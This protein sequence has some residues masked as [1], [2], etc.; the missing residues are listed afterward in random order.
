MLGNGLV[1]NFWL[2]SSSTRRQIDL[3]SEAEAGMGVGISSA[4][5]GRCH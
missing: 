4:L 2:V 3:F 1:L 5:S